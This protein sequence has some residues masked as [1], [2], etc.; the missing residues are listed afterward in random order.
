MGDPVVAV[1]SSSGRFFADPCRLHGLLCSGWPCSG[2]RG[3]SD[4]HSVVKPGDPEAIEQMFDDVAPRYDQL[5]DLLSFGLHRYWKRQL[6]RW[7]RPVPGETWLDLCCGTGDLALQLARY[8]RPSG[9]VIGL[10][11]AFAPLQLARLRQQ[12]EPWLQ[13][14]WFQG[15]ALDTGLDDS[16]VDGA[17]MAYGLR[18]L[19]DPA[20]GLKELRRLVRAGGRAGIL[21]FNRLQPTD[22]LGQFQRFY[23]RRLVVPIAAINGLADHYAYLEESLQR[24]PDGAMQEQMAVRAGFVEARHRT[25]MAGQMGILLLEG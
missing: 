16:C 2:D 5:N 7:L 1:S 25:L 23:L 9:R 21:D 20:A 4:W 6:I 12:R 13:V 10:D 8:V 22:P 11:T 14:E 17:L 24:F 18:N 15:D 19:K 3:D